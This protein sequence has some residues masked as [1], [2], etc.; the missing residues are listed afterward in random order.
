[1][2]KKSALPPEQNAR[3]VLY[4]PDLCLEGI[5]VLAQKYQTSLTSTAIRFAQRTNI[6]GAIFGC[7]N[8]RITWVAKTNGLDNID[9]RKGLL[10]QASSK[11][12][13]QFCRI[14]ISDF[15]SY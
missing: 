1:M 9:L 7:H 6:P 15:A 8:G 14:F 2:I 5:P 3:E 10:S 12:K 11:E 4:L 13:M